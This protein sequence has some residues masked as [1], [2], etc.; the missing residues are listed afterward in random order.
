MR[1]LLMPAVAG[2]AVSGPVA[3]QEAPFMIPGWMPPAPDPLST[4]VRGYLGGAVEEPNA[5]P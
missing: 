5:R 4:A 3:P 1:A 2:F